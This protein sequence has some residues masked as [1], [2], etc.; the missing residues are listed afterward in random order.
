MQQVGTEAPYSA[1]QRRRVIVLAMLGTLLDGVDFTIMLYFLVPISRYFHVPLAAVAAIQAVSY[2]AGVAGGV[3]FGIVADRWGRRLGLTLTVGLF[4]VLSLVAALSPNFA[5]LFVVKVLMGIPIGGETGIAMAYL[6]EAMPGQ[7]A[8][9]GLATGVL[10]AMFQLGL[11]VTIGVFTYT[12]SS[13]GAGAWRYAFGILGL[14]AV[15]A[16][17][18]RV[19]MPESRLWLAARERGATSRERPVVGLFQSG[20]GRSTIFASLLLTAVFFAGFAFGTY[21]PSTWQS[22]YRLAPGTVALI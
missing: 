18:M 19:A 21:S 9:R 8:R 14:G 4:S 20:L 3:L 2:V 13:F 11:F 6:N 1:A 5:F 15:A 16:G 7:G 22:V 12:A 17:L 10:Q